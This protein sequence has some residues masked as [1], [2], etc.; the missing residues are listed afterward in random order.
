MISP[1]PTINTQLTFGQRE[2]RRPSLRDDVEQLEELV[3]FDSSRVN[4]K[5]RTYIDPGFT[6]INIIPSGPML[7]II[8]QLKNIDLCRVAQVSRRF[9][10]LTEQ[11]REQLYSSEDFDTIL[12]KVVGGTADIVGTRFPIWWLARHHPERKCSPRIL[13]WASAMGHTKVVKLLLEADK[14]C[15]N[16]AFDWAA[17]SGYTEIVKLL[18]A[19]NKDCTKW[20]LNWASEYGHTEIVKLLLAA[21]KDYTKWAYNWA[22][23]NGHTEIVKLLLAAPNRELPSG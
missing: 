22:A 4:P 1:T 9:N 16:W 12:G 19:A 13:D 6:G 15:T 18:L 8:S 23:I 5:G 7:Y 3:L 20:A 11:Y 10:K 17:I 21:N 14:S 2:L